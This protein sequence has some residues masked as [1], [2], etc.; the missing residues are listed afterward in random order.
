MDSAWWICILL[1]FAVYWLGRPLQL[2]QVET[3]AAR[4]RL[5]NLDLHYRWDREELAVRREFKASMSKNGAFHSIE[6]PMLRAPVLGAAL[7]KGKKHEWIVFLFLARDQAKLLYFNKG[8]DKESVWPFVNSRT[9]LEWVR[10][11]HAHTVLRL[12]NHPHGTCWPRQQD[13]RSGQEYV[14]FFLK[15]GIAFFDFVCVAGRFREY[16]AAVPEGRFPQSQFLHEIERANGSGWWKNCRLRLELMSAPP[17][18]GNR[19]KVM[20]SCTGRTVRRDAFG[21]C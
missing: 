10:R 6:E 7:L 20:S 18:A 15:A 9:L 13:L 21:P 2:G 5:R 17:T 1:L 14:D 4:R 3:L 16:L 8:P 11:L 12:H 19:F